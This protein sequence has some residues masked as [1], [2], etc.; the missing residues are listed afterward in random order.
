MGEYGR[1][2]VCVTGVCVT[3]L[4]HAFYQFEVPRVGVP[5]PYV[6]VSI[7]QTLGEYKVPY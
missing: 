7:C 4:G 2:L 1:I 6:F 3:V 5:W